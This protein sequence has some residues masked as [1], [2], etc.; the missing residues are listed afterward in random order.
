MRD[1]AGRVQPE[2]RDSPGT[3]NS[4]V[5]AAMVYLA[6]HHGS[7]HA[8][9]TDFARWQLRE[10]AANDFAALPRDATWGIA[11]SNLAL[12]CETLGDA[13]TAALLYPLLEPWAGRSLTAL[14][15][16][17]A[18]C[19]AR[20]LGLLDAVLGRHAEAAARFE[21]ALAVDAR[22]EAT[23]WRVHTAID[24]ARTLLPHLP[25]AERAH[26]TTLLRSAREDAARLGLTVPLRSADALLAGE[27]PAAH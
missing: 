10:L 25:E 13:D 1:D 8:G 19:G 9:A 23:A 5:K 2:L 21:A 17:N 20:F 7:G 4:L 16:Y 18:G 3:P 12:S 24:Y 26:V 27:Q 15:Y 22:M 14:C 11:L 6:A